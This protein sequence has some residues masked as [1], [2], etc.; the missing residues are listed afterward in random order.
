M[1]QSLPNVHDAT[2]PNLRHGQEQQKPA[3]MGVARLL[4]SIF[5]LESAVTRNH[6]F[7]CIQ[8]HCVNIKAQRDRG[9]NG[10]NDHVAK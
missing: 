5:R 2:C 3:H 9:H 8:V 6:V 7:K 4:G 1:T 10:H